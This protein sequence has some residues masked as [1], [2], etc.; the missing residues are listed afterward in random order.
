MKTVLSVG[1]SVLAPDLD[2]ERIREY[3]DMITGLVEGGHEVAVVVGG[4][5]MAREYIGTA[6]S[7][8][9]NE[10]QLDRIGIGATRL[11]A[12]LLIAALDA[13]GANPVVTPPE[14]YA[15]A[16]T[17]LRRGE[18][19]VMG[20]TEPAHTT[21]AVSA[22]LAED[23]GADRLVYATNTQG[24]FNADPSEDETAERFEEIT[25]ATL[26]KTIAELGLDAGTSAPVDLLAALIIQRAGVEAIVLDGSDPRRVAKAALGEE[27]DGTRVVADASGAD[28]LEGSGPDGR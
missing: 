19:P 5:P 10:I 9:A 16:N 15:T 25:A 26:V 21:D 20:G 7:L 23:S 12:H 2:P 11:N 4:G 8:G 24:V 1:G 28:R 27:F 6:R 18:I 22:A 3:A 13:A 17:A 14:D